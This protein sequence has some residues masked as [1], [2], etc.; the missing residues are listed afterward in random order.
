ML[1]V[2]FSPQFYFDSYYKENPGYS[3][4]IDTYDIEL[5]YVKK[6]ND[7]H[8]ISIGTG[9]RTVIDD[10]NPSEIIEFSPNNTQR[11]TFRIYGQDEISLIENELALIL[12]TKYERN[13]HTGTEWQP[14]AKLI[15]TPNKV[16]TFWAGNHT[17]CKKHLPE[18]KMI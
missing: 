6:L 17:S 15:W 1:K 13:D 18:Q 11:D 12:G 4:G 2:L 14:S 7:I 16:N 10:F 8:K 9:Y 3:E 5:R